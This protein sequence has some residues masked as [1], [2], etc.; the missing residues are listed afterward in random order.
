MKNII[1]NKIS[2]IY[3]ILALTFGVIISLA[4]PF[5]NEPDGQY[6][7]M[8]SSAITRHTVD[9]S[10]Y[11]EPK[12]GTGMNMQK[13][14]YQNG[15]RFEK[16]YLTKATIMSPLQSPRGLDLDNKLSYNY[17]GHIIP[18]IGIW[19]GHRVYSSLGVMIT[20]G[21]L[22]SMFVYTMA[23]YFIIKKV[24]FGKLTFMLVS[25]SPVIMNQFSSLS[26]DGLGYIVTAA[27]VA[28]AINTIAEKS[29]DK[30]SLLYMFIL[31]V[32]SIFLIK[33]NLLLANLLFPVA[34]VY[35]KLEENKQEAL[36]HSLSRKR[37]FNPKFSL[38]KKYKYLF[39]GAG[40]IFAFLAVLHM[41]SS[42][43]GLLEVMARIWMSL[44]FQFFNTM[45]TTNVINL[46]VAPYPGFNYMPPWLIGLWF[47][48]LFIGLLVDKKVYKSKFISLSSLGIIVLGVV[49]VY[50]GFLYSGSLVSS[51]GVR[52]GIQ[53]VQGRY[54]TPLLLILPLVFSNEKIKLKVLGYHKVVLLMIFAVV[55]SN[56]LLVFN[57][58]WAMIYV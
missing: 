34:L 19:I 32:S 2:K 5:F 24:K 44:T 21:R 37:K 42:S 14:S 29:F 12:V 53:G 8:V 51:F 33:P 10:R 13:N 25:L 55:I 50:Y 49:S 54:S 27:I 41:A 11:G 6:H 15:K 36:L 46:L 16:Y 22:F 48:L 35:V 26:Y 43:G 52:F 4:M 20:F 40:A 31:A 7:F 45:S 39:I 17:L 9:I 38:I 58:L 57:T 23:M 56:F 28:L 18:A 30:R 1:E 47:G 3:L